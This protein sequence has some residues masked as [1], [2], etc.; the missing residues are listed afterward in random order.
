MAVSEHIARAGRWVAASRPGFLSVTLV[1]TTTGI[2]QA[3]ACGCGWD[4]L[5]AVATVLLALLTH[6][7][8]NLWNDYGDA[9]GG[10]DAVNTG[11]IGPFTGGSRFIQD[12]V[13]SAAQVRTAAINLAIVVIGG[14][15]LLTARA[16]PGLLLL[17]LAG[18][19]LGWAYSSPRVALMSR[20]LGELSVAA[21]WWLIVVGADYVQRHAFSAIAMV[22][23]LSLALLVMNVLWVAQY[24]DAAADATVGKRTLVVRWGPRPAAWAHLGSVLLAHGWLLAGWWADVLPMTAWWAL[25]SLALSLPS[26]VL[27]IARADRPAVLKPAIVLAIAAAVSHG[28]LLTAA[29]V[30]I[31][32]LR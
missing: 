26:A 3:Q 17:G 20:G 6:A 12:G 32:R 4:P 29:F 28:A 23:G 18:A 1:A 15:L 14:G 27:V 21:G 9:V 16:G 24:P 19:L 31:A 25:G 30:A 2:A 7:A 22:S 10:S 5:G 8:V 13:F 11:R